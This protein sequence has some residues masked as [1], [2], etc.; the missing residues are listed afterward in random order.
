[1]QHPEKKIDK[2]NCRHHARCTAMHGC[3]YWQ[4]CTTALL[5][6]GCDAKGMTP[7][8]APSSPCRA[9]HTGRTAKAMQGDRAQKR[10]PQHQKWTSSSHQRQ[11]NGISKH[12]GWTHMTHNRCYAIR[13]QPWSPSRSSTSYRA[14]R[15]CAWHRLHTGHAAEKLQQAQKATPNS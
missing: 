3:C 9:R 14:F 6:C 5:L 13:A 11:L 12:T 4:R 10:T 15:L 8:Y 7:A 1:M 2:A